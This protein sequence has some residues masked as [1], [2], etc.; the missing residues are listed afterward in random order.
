MRKLLTLVAATFI[1]ARSPAQ[2]TLVRA[3]HLLDPRTGNV[4]SPAAV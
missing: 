3:G 2:V 4:L 1:A